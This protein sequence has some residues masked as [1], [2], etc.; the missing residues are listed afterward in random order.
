MVEDLF[1]FKLLQLVEI[2]TSG[3]QGY[4]IA[5]INSVDCENKYCVRCQN[6]AGVG[7]VVEVFLNESALREVEIEEPSEGG[8]CD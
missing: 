2:N 6:V 4:V 8:D 5:R 1:G 7:A 3:E